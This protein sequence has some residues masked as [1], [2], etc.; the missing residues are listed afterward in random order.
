MLTEETHGDSRETDTA[1]TQQQL[2]HATRGICLFDFIV[3]INRFTIFKAPVCRVT[4]LGIA[5]GNNYI[6]NSK[7]C[8]IFF[9]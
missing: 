1:A 5:L 3:F 9:L 8:Q 7:R 2:R 4:L 6:L